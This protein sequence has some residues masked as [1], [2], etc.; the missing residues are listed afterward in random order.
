MSFLIFRASIHVYHCKGLEYERAAQLCPWNTAEMGL[1]SP[2][3]R[4]H[5]SKYKAEEGR[6][7][8]SVQKHIATPL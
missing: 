8:I 4:S 7:C 2:H 1:E 6:Q 3:N 5:A